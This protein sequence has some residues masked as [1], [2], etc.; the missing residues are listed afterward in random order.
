MT[1]LHKLVMWLDN[2]G[3]HSGKMRKAELRYIRTKAH[4]LLAQEKKRV[5]V[6]PY[7]QKVVGGFTT[8][9]NENM[10]RCQGYMPAKPKS[11]IHGVPLTFSC[12]DC[13]KEEL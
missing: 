7:C 13:K 1:E 3:A 10:G 5:V 4:E 11:C 6:C 2:R 8:C 9:K 12:P